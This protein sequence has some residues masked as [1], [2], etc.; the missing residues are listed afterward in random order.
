MPHR[1]RRPGRW[2]ALAPLLAAIGLFALAAPA[3]AM[4][5]PAVAAAHAIGASA[6]LVADVDTIGGIKID[7]VV[8]ELAD[9]N[10]AVIGSR[11]SESALAGVA[12][13]AKSRGLQLAIVSLGARLTESDANL[14]AQELRSRVGGT[15]L[16]LTPTSGGVDSSTLSGTQQSAA[17]AAAAKAGDDDVA[18]STA[19]VDSATAKGFPTV[20]VVVGVIVVLIVA[21]IVA[22]YLRRRRT[23]Q[24]DHASLAVRTAELADRVGKLSPLILA[25]APRMDVAKRP[26]LSARFNQAG[27]DYTTLRDA[28]AKPLAT[29]SEIDAAAAEIADL[30]RRLGSLD[31]QLDTLLP[32]M[33]PPSPAG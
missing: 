11:A 9:D 13:A 23:Q 7:T 1:R 32:G 25:I 20:L 31:E 14:M 28:V 26:D 3:A 24:Q 12:A 30:Q 19:F 6:E 10:V 27:A 21:V 33:E 4:P 5:S 29:G 18:A 17:K 15:V 8:S 16:V 22:G 2:P